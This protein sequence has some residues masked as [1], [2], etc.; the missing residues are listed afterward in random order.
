MAEDED[1]LHAAQRA[2]HQAFAQVLSGT[3]QITWDIW[4]A[5][6]QWA[7]CLTPD[8][9]IV[10]H[11]AVDVLRHTLGENF[12]A[13]LQASGPA[14]GAHPM[15]SPAILVT[16]SPFVDGRR[17]Y[18]DLFRLAALLV[19]AARNGQRRARVVQ[20]MRTNFDDTSWTHALL[21]LELLGLAV[22]HSWTGTF[23][24]PL[25]TGRPGDLL[26]ER[27]AEHSPV[28]LLI[29]CTSMGESVREREAFAY[30]DWLMQ[31]TRVI[32]FGHNVHIRGEL[33][34]M[35]PREAA[36]RWLHEIEE[37]ARA[38]AQDGLER[39]VPRP[40]ITFSTVEHGEA[41]DDSQ[42]A[43]GMEQF[44]ADGESGASGASDASEGTGEMGLDDEAAE[45]WVT[46]QLAVSAGETVLSGGVVTGEPWPRLE[47]RIQEKAR[48]TDGAG[49]TTWIRIE[50][51]AGFWLFT[52]LAHLSLAERL[53]DLGPWLR[54]ALEPFPHVAGI[55]LSPGP[56]WAT[57]AIAETEDAADPPGLAGAVALR[58]PVAQGRVRETLIVSRSGHLDAGGEALAA[59][60][61]QEASWLSWA[62][63]ELGHPPVAAL[64]R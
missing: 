49:E 54:A 29:E 58:R 27:G 62:L 4:A 6:I 21:Q 18:E 34:R 3:Q 32:E 19:V 31:R 33:G 7:T 24:P 52:R 40:S 12:L 64:F 23:E 56:M 10:A 14:G 16:L 37:A 26:L 2:Y 57:D 17:V 11:W 55:V 43:D 8:G 53:T 25:R 22:R 9:R 50:D 44:R 60:Y 47:A 46:R 28:R 42:E 5:P 59:W 30:Y 35:V 51:Q 45:V 15:L 61:G 63:Q 36:E 41:K 1:V 48:Q 20:T 38:T 13:R 39:Y